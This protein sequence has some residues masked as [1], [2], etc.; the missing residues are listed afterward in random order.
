MK[1][2]AFSKDQLN[3]LYPLIE[4]LNQFLLLHEKNLDQLKLVSNSI[5]KIQGLQRDQLTGTYL[6]YEL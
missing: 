1:S 3:I 2:N 6:F 4:K 5:E